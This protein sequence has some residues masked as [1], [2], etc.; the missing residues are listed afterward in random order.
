[1]SES[2]PPP[3]DDRT[4]VPSAGLQTTAILL[5]EA[6][7][8]SE[9]ALNLLIERLAPRLRRWATG[10]LPSGARS[11]TDT[12]DL[13]QD[14]LIQT[15]RRIESFRPEHGGAF[16]AY[17][18]RAVLNRMRD[19]IRRAA[20]GEKA[21]DVVEKPVS[22]FHSPLEELIGSEMLERYESALERLK[23]SDREAIIA[24]IELNCEYEEIADL[25]GSAS[26]HA[27]R[28]KV[29]RALVRLAKEMGHGTG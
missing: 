28:M 3:E 4:D 27:A 9:R 25:V 23:D 14:A 22:P 8:G 2:H 10:R 26:P 18:R 16:F 19:Q 15:V 11:L 13:V 17:L 7:G 1:M 24:K 12:E 5:D 6:R 21:M 20:V 29:K